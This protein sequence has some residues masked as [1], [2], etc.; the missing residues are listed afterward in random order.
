MVKPTF[1]W[2][3]SC[4]TCRNARGYLDKLGIQVEERD[5]NKTP[6]SREFLE[7]HVD[8]QRFLDF[9]SKRSPVFKERPLPRSK[10]EA[11]DLMTKQGGGGQ[12]SKFDELA[13]YSE[14]FDTVEINTTFYGQPKPEIAK[15]WA[16]RTPPTSEFSLK[17]YRKFTHPALSEKATGKSDVR[18]NVPGV[19]RL[20][21]PE[22]DAFRQGIEPLAKEGKIGALLAQFP[23]SFKQSQQSLEYLDA[24]LARFHDYPV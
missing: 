14:H 18:T 23:P 5:I 1:Y 3:P 24:L 7:A 13:F 17:L 16:K 12:A 11:I 21:I 6:P 19:P 2:K 10:K 4:T 20:D 9:V 8:E 15:S 22:I